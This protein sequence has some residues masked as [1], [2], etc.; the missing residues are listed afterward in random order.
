MDEGTGEASVK[1]YLYTVGQEHHYMFFADRS[2]PWQWGTWSSDA[3]FAYWSVSLE[4]GARQ[5]VLCEA[6]YLDIG[7]QRVISCA[8][9]LARIEWL[10]SSKAGRIFCSDE[11]SLSQVHEEALSLAGLIE[12]VEAVT[13]RERIC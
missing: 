3:R 7:G 9:R 5:C 1:V 13:F 8:R 10:S 11:A 2:Q 6:S 4:S 12:Q